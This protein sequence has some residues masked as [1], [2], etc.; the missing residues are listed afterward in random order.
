MTPNE[1]LQCAG[2]ELDKIRPA[3]SGT[4]ELVVADGRIV[5]RPY[6]K[7]NPVLPLIV[8]LNSDGVNKGCRSKTWE[9]IEARI[10]R[11][12]EKGILT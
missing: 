4:Y 5:V 7:S 8:R 12:V 11:F 10:R 1:Y 9:Q 6:L 2:V 3:P